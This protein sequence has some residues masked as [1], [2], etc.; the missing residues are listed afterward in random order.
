M[1]GDP[2][3]DNSRTAISAA[4]ADNVGIFVSPITAW[5]I[6]VLSARNRIQL[7]LEPQAWFDTLL[8]WPGVRLAPMPPSVL[9]ASNLLPG[10]P[11]RDP[12][13][14]IIAATARTFGYAVVTRNGE[15]TAYAGAGHIALIAC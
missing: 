5:E 3:L 15:L 13:D 1:N 10:V 14:R 4:R 9:I 2:M 7:T 12:A 11:P 8:D 6:G